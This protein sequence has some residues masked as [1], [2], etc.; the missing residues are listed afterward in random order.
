MIVSFIDGR[1][2]LR[3][4]VL[5]SIAVAEKIQKDFM[6][7]KGV[8]NVSVNNKTGGMLIIYDSKSVD[9][10]S[11]IHEANL[12]AHTRTNDK[13]SL[14]NSKKILNTGM[15]ASLII[16]LLSAAAGFSH[17]HVAGGVVFVSFAFVHIYRHRL[18]L[19][20]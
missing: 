1:I 9:I 17:L 18:I 6:L 19:F 2:R 8:I 10:R 14:V 5:K 3:H 4:E 20:T 11:I 7:A 15:L 12:S 13:V 16:S